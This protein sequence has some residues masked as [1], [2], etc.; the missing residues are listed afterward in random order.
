[1]PVLNTKQSWQPGSVVQCGFLILRVVGCTPVKDG[2]PDIYSLESLDGRKFY[3]FIP[4][5]GLKGVR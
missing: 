3:T 2:M 5:F 4:H 1:M